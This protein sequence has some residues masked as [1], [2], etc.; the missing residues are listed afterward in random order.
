MRKFFIFGL[1]LILFLNCSCNSQTSQSIKKEFDGNIAME[2]VKHQVSLGPRIPGTE[3]HKQC[4]NWIVENLKSFNWIVESQPF[5][6][7]NKQITNI[8]AKNRFGTPDIIIGAHYDTRMYA[9]Q[10]PNPANRLKPVPGANDGASGV[11]A[12]VE[13]ARILPLTHPKNIWLVFFDAEDQGNIHNMSWI[14]GSRLFAATLVEKPQKVIILDMIGDESLD[15][16]YEHN[17]DP[18]I[19]KSIWEKG[20]QLGYQKHFIPTKKHSLLDD[21]TPFIELGI[22]SIDIIDFDYPYWHTISDTTDKV[23]AASLEVVGKTVYAWLM[24]Q[25]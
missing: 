22:S 4:V 14:M 9:D 18:D 15:L 20:A 12:L 23:S 6:Y 19:S 24:D 21:H 17:S 3:A 7:Q 10:D 13:L 16:Y 1:L 5:P 25:K 11:S 8:I 2:H